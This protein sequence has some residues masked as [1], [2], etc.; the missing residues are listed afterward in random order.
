[1]IGIV[2]NGRDKFTDYGYKLAEE[3]VKEII[4]ISNPEKVCSGNSPMLGIDYLVKQLTPPERY[5][6]FAPQ[7]SQWNPKEGIG[8]RERNLKIAESSVV[9]VIVANKYPKYYSGDKFKECYHCFNMQ[10]MKFDVSNHLPTN[11][12]KSGGCWT[13]QHTIMNGNKALWYIIDNGETYE[14]ISQDEELEPMEE[15]ELESDN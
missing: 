3:K 11:H 1:M 10:R 5:I 2:G 13:G 12:V 9:Y 15:L 8:F 7:V 14:N 4:T 6:E